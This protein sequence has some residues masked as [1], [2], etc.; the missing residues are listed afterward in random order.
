MTLYP[1]SGT[2]KVPNFRPFSGSSPPPPTPISVVQVTTSNTTTLTFTNPTT[3]G[4]LLVVCIGAFNVAASTSG[5]TIGGSADN[6]AQAITPIA[7]GACIGMMWADF[8]CGVSDTSVVVSGSNLVV[9]NGNG[10]LVAYEIAGTLT[11][12]DTASTLGTTGSSTWDS[13]T[14]P[15]TTKANEIWVGMC[16]ANRAIASQP[17]AFTNVTVGAT[18]VMGAGYQI[19]STT[20]APDYTGTLTGSDFACAAILPIRGF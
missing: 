6:F 1:F 11:A 2:F 17:G 19:V 4:N 9:S 18:P 20:G 5:V 10:G 12:F 7:Q 3:K 13:G 14:A 8:D 16:E 15:T